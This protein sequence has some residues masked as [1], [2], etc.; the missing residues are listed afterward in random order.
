[1][2]TRND[3]LLSDGGQLLPLRLT[4]RQHYKA[5]Y[6]TVCHAQDVDDASLLLESLGLTWA[7]ARRGQRVARGQA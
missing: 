2:P 1:M 6:A 3:D 7:H 5:A 4:A